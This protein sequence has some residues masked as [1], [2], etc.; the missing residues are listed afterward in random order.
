MTRLSRTVARHWPFMSSRRRLPWLNGPIAEIPSGEV[1]D[2]RHGVRV[3]VMPDGMYRDVYFWS[4]YEPYNTKIFRRIVRPGDVALDV[5]ANFG[6]FTVLFARWVGEAGHV[7]AFEPVPY[8]RKLAEETIA[9]NGVGSRVTLNQVGLGRENATS[10]IFTFSGLPHG[11]ASGTDLGREDAVR[12]DCQIRRLDDYCHEQ[13]IDAVGFMKVD[14]E[15]FERDVFAGAERIL[16]S[17]DAPIVAF[18]I[19]RGCL[20]HRS[21]TPSAV[22]AP[23]RDF[24]Y[25]EFFTFSTRAGVERLDIEHANGDCLAAKRARLGDLTSALKTGRFLRE[26]RQ[27]L[28][29]T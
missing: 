1:I 25:S 6:W 12:H 14:V 27:S 4:D 17:R 18:E 15:G 22:V 24:G 19:N 3:R 13:G 21:L 7:H 29:Q 16:S 11:H 28:R 23:L 9:L 2:T 26:M 5:G 10:P 20:A 8:I